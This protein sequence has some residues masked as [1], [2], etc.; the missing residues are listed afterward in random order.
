MFRA[1]FTFWGTFSRK[2]L[3]K[4]GTEMSKPNF[5]GFLDCCPPEISLLFLSDAFVFEISEKG[6]ATAW[7][8]AA[9]RY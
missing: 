3:V 9:F 8:P 6:T 5:A 4:S 2:I 7:A 1:E